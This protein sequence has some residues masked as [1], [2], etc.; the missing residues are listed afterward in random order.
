MRIKAVEP[1]KNSKIAPPRETQ[2]NLKNLSFGTPWF[3]PFYG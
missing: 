1:I 2:L 3:P